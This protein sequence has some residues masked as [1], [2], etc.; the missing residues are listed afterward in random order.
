M[1][2]RLTT[3]S[4]PTEHSHD[5]GNAPSLTNSAHTSPL[6]PRADSQTLP[7][8]DLHDDDRRSNASGAD[9]GRD[10]SLVAIWSTGRG[11]SQ[12]LGQVELGDL[13]RLRV[14]NRRSTDRAIEDLGL[15]PM[16]RSYG[17]TIPLYRMFLKDKTLTWSWSVFFRASH[18]PRTRLVV[19]RQPRG[20]KRPPSSM[21]DRQFSL[22]DAH[23]T[24][25]LW[26]FPTPHAFT[27]KRSRLSHRLFPSST[28]PTSCICSNQRI[29]GILFLGLFT[30]TISSRS[31]LCLV[32]SRFQSDRSRRPVVCFPPVHRIILETNSCS[33]LACSACK[34]VLLLTPRNK[35]VCEASRG[36]MKFMRFVNIGRSL[37]ER[38]SMLHW[39]A[40]LK[41]DGGGGA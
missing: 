2:I 9:D 27:H 5:S 32:C 20:G 31:P 29:L 37:V 26:P 22:N 12:E 3:T 4:G 11:G 18:T 16:L 33:T 8:W 14:T 24:L 17:A 23:C 40:K 10:G 25:L 41:F 21:S 7:E 30:I 34:H 6:S 38:A 36:K 19:R 1:T 13:H 35:N 28:W 15:H 39:K